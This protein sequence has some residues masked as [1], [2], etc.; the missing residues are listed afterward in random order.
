VPTFWIYSANFLECGG[1]RSAT[2]LW[3]PMARCS[4]VS[5]APSSLR[6]AGALQSG[7]RFAPLSLIANC[8]PHGNGR[9][10]PD[11]PANPDGIP[12]CHISG[13][14]GNTST[15]KN[16]TE[17]SAG[18]LISSFAPVPMTGPPTGIQTSPPNCGH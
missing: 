13:F 6:S 14:H 7:L 8:I 5:K 9:T 12:A 16:L 11:Y 2:P 4:G 18:T 1:K 3:M 17:L 15:R 10:C